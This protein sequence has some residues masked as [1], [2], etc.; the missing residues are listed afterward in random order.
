MAHKV[1]LVKYNGGNNKTIWNLGIVLEQ[2]LVQRINFSFEPHETELDTNQ[3]FWH[4][5]DLD[6]VCSLETHTWLFRVKKS[7]QWLKKDLMFRW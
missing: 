4:I 5:F 3:T 1:S 7:V 6:I 2:Q